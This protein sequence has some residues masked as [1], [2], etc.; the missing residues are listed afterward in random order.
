[1]FKF[2]SFCLPPCFVLQFQHDFSNLYLSLSVRD[3]HILFESYVTSFMCCASLR[4]NRLQISITLCGFP[5]HPDDSL[6]EK[7][8]LLTCLST[9]AFIYFQLFDPL[10]L[11]P[12]DAQTRLLIWCCLVRSLFW[13]QTNFL[14]LLLFAFVTVFLFMLFLLMLSLMYPGS[15]FNVPFLK[16]HLCNK[17][18]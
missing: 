15:T 10:T 8:L 7:Y 5:D 18:C 2:R 11:S 1:M 9:N 17:A 13:A 12:L 14:K 4:H 16:G 3:F 6:L